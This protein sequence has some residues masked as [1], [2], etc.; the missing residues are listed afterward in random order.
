MDGFHEGERRSTYSAANFVSV[1]PEA[2]TGKGLPPP[3]SRERKA[4]AAALAWSAFTVSG[5]PKVTRRGL[6][7]RRK[8]NTQDRAPFGW[9]LSM[10]PCRAASWIAYSCS[11]GRAARA[12]ASVRRTR[13]G[14]WSASPPSSIAASP[15]ETRFARVEHGTLG[16]MRVAEG[17]RDVGMAEQP[18][19]DAKALAAIDRDRRMAMAQI[20]NAERPQP[21]R[22]ADRLPCLVQRDRCAV[23]RREHPRMLAVVPGCA[24]MV[25]FLS[26]RW[27]LADG[28][29][30]GLADFV[31]RCGYSVEGPVIDLGAVRRRGRA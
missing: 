18:G 7:S 13:S 29:L 23:Q 5:L 14:H 27:R 31:S 16:E 6:P 28:M 19:D 15:R 4:S 12:S 10:K 30:L 2:G 24:Y 1:G 22:C 3:F 21:R 8:R 17:G 25:L 11:R 9:T 26:G 20:V